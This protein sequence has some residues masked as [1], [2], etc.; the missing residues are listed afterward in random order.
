MNLH[1]VVRGAI[2]AVNPDISATYYK[3]TGY[4]TNANY[5]QVPA[6]QTFRNVRIQ[7]QAMAEGALLGLAQTDNINLEHVVKKVYMYGN[8]QG[9]VRPSEKGGDLI[10]F[11][12][13][14]WLVVKVSET[15]PQWSSVIVEMQVDQVAP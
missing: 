3:S 4:T 6:Y 15:W 10:Q 2:T 12:G 1:G 14:F 9:I 5:N 8:T 7:A 13:N 11:D